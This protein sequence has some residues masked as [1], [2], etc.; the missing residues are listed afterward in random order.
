[1]VTGLA[2]VKREVQHCDLSLYHDK[3][4]LEIYREISYMFLV[5][6]VANIMGLN[7][8]YSTLGFLIYKYNLS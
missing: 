3:L 2:F 6:N 1:M 4:S 8:W 7:F 5:S